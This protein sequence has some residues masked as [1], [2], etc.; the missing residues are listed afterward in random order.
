LNH[1]FPRHEAV[2]NYSWAVPC[3]TT[4]DACVRACAGSPLLELGSGSG[5][6]ANLLAA[7]GL[8]V[9][10]VDSGREVKDGAPFSPYFSYA[11]RQ[12]AREYLEQHGGCPDSTLFLCWPRDADDWLRAYKGDTVIWV[13]ETGGCTWK[14]PV[15]E[16]EWKAVEA[17]RIRPGA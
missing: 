16:G 6:W 15:E 5:Y 17:V 4:I 10:A 9:I 7:H 14:M 13:G 8:S 1:L 11:I 2:C 12:D 3:D